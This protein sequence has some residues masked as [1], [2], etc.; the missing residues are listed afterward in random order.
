MRK[1]EHET[2]RAE[3]AARKLSTR[4]NGLLDAKGGLT[5]F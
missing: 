3:R 2:P 1:K 4:V 5:P